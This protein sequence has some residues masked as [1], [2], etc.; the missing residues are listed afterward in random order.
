MQE[1]VQSD[2]RAALKY[3][4]LS[5]TSSNSPTFE[6]GVYLDEVL[7]GKGTGKTKK[8]AEQSAAKEALGKL[9]K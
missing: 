1:Y 2:I 9:V 8:K 5:E 4:L 7:L 6:M 3:E